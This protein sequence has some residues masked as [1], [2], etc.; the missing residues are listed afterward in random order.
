MDPEIIAEIMK[1]NQELRDE[2]KDLKARITE[3]QDKERENL[4]H[5]T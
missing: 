5:P 3:Y 4:I 2:V 1:Q